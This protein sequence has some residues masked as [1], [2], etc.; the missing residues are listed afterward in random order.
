MHRNFA[1]RFMSGHQR[2]DMGFLFSTTPMMP[3]SSLAHYLN[4]AVQCRSLA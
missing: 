1:D 3:N 4:P 2:L